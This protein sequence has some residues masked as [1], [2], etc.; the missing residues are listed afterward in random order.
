MLPFPRG[1]N[2]ATLFDI[3]ARCRTA[4]IK[5]QTTHGYTRR[6]M[7]CRA[8]CTVYTAKGAAYSGRTVLLSLFV[9][10]VCYAAYVVG[11]LL[12]LPEC[13]R[14]LQLAPAVSPLACNGNVSLCSRRYSQ[15]SFACMHNA[16]ST[17]QDGM[18][19]AQHRGCMRS[20][21]MHGIRAFMLDVHLTSDDKLKL[22]HVSCAAG[23]VSL[24]Q[25]LD[26]LREFL[27]LNPREVVTVIWEVGFDTRFDGG[28]NVP[29]P[30]E[31]VFENMLKAAYEEAALG[32]Y[33]FEFRYS[34][35][36]SLWHMILENTR[37]VT[38]SS[39]NSSAEMPWNLHYPRYIVQT[40]W[41]SA[42]AQ[43]LRAH[44]SLPGLATYTPRH[45]LVVINHFTTLGAAGVNS[46]T[47]SVLVE[48]LGIDALRGINRFSF[49]HER[50]ISCSKCLGIFPNFI[51]VD[52]WMSSD[53]MDVVA[54]LNRVSPSVRGEY[55]DK[56]VTFC[57]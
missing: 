8:R 46:A 13:V 11:E 52:F 48:G 25:T 26:T 35:W 56:N 22:C 17:T 37:L 45:S 49:M 7:H 53:V 27:E 57:G 34:T 1:A 14:S 15:V 38:F 31:A 2:V 44:C 54:I 5:Q 42:D 3:I 55:F 23:A 12:L 18:P 10:A 9:L 28:R 32:A 47:V 29:K 30:V 36:P 21:L 6:M 24:A 39:M 50:I 19:M 20:A 16:Y 4:D 40:P 43:E 51:A 33:L 41:D